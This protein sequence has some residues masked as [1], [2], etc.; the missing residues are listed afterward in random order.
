[1][2]HTTEQ[3]RFIVRWFFIWCAFGIGV[4]YFSFF[5]IPLIVTVAL[6]AYYEITLFFLPLS[7]IVP[8]L[9]H[10][11]FFVALVISMID[12]RIRKFHDEDTEEGNSTPRTV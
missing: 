6:P 7:V 1:M 12:D 3:T 2:S 11:F 4:S 5:V 10:L 9:L 8:A